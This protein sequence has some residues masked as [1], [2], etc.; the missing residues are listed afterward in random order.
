[1]DE[2]QIES[3]PGRR[4][5]WLFDGSET[6]AA[7]IASTSD[8][9]DLIPTIVAYQ[10]EWNKMHRIIDEDERLQELIAL[11]ETDGAVLTSQQIA[12]VG[13]RLLLSTQDWNRLKGI[14][15][16]RLWPNLR[17]ISADKKKYELRMLGGSYVGYTRATRQWY[18][19]VARLLNELELDQRPVYFVSSNMHSFTNVLSGTARR[20][21]DGLIKHIKASDD[22]ELTAELEKIEAGETISSLDNLLYFAAR[23]YFA[24]PAQRPDRDVRTREELERGIYHIDPQAGIDVGVQIIDLAKLDTTSFDS[25]LCSPGESLDPTVTDAIIL[26]VNYPLG[27]SAYHLLSQVAM[28]NDEVRGIYILG[29]AATLNGRIGDVMLANVV[30]D[31]HSGNTYWFDNCFTYGDLAPYLLFGAALDN[32]KAVTVKGTYLQNQGYLDFYYRENF[33]VVEM[34]AGP[35][36]DAIYE[37]SRLDR[38]PEDEAINLRGAVGHDIDLGIIH[39]ASDTPYTR[40]QT[41]GARGMSFY[42]M[43]ST[44]AS[45]IAILRRVFTKTGILTRDAQS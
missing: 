40:A 30:F 29:K 6:L 11:T 45:T 25:R 18:A 19:P 32:Q 37:D 38:F 7:Y 28:A 14:W 44:Y 8:L 22:A 3:A 16:A 33:T 41:L 26:N 36:L 12:E 42:G 43:D 39:Y 13:E 21:Q 27:F 10:I 2:W 15:G 35:Y 20:R 23:S 31:E 4:R 1:M 17:L 34:E 24:E 5:R 9:D